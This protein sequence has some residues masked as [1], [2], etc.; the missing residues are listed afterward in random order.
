M[1]KKFSSL[2]T[3]LVLA[4][5]M[6]LA[7]L[8]SAC[9]AESGTMDAAH[10]NSVAAGGEGGPVITWKMGSTWGS[11]NVHFTC[12]QRFSELVSQL[13]GGRFTI[14]NYSEGEL[15][16]A[17][18]LFD[19]VQDGTIQCGG[20]WGGYW[21]GKDPTFELLSTTMDNFNGM[22]YFIWIYQANGLHCYQSMYGQ[23]NMV[24][25]PIMINHAESGIRSVRPITS[26]EDM[27]KMKIRLGGVMAG[28]VGQKLGINITTVAAAELYE[29]LQ[30]GVI[31][32]GEFSTPCSDDSLKL[33]EVAKYW[34]APAWYQSAGVNGVMINKEA[35]DK[36]PPEYQQAVEIAA[37]TCASEQ[38]ARYLWMDFESVEKMLN[39]DGCIVTQMVPEDAKTIRE[40]CLE[41][42]RE[43]AENN[44]NFAKVYGS[45]MAYRLKADRYRDMLGDY[46]WGFNYDESVDIEGLAALAPPEPVDKESP[47]VTA[48]AANGTAGQ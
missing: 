39:E 21:S 36:L 20:D 3:G 15:C 48:E 18:Q 7:L 24:Y 42:Y 38:L 30:R 4:F 23:Y 41:V 27:Q 25:F 9:G 22:D 47:T 26:I 12:D 11:G 16:A 5:S 28:R 45:M 33:Q 43:E 6:G 17:S 37:K 13:T 8:T 2:I 34:C 35:W 46:S 29:S 40:T 31:D 1:S 44:P 10:A 19:Y 14:T 32:G